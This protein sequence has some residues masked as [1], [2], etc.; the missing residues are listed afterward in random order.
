MFIP[1]ARD[2]CGS[3]DSI[4]RSDHDRDNERGRGHE[5]CNRD[6]GQRPLDDSAV[7]VICT[8]FDSTLVKP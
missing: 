8:A 7:V 2:R 6:E 3:V 5:K 1:G 4:G